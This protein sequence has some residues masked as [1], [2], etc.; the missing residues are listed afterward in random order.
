MATIMPAAVTRNVLTAAGP[1]AAPPPCA[2]NFDVPTTTSDRMTSI[3]L[4]GT[5]RAMCAWKRAV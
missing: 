1:A 2:A 4:R 3:R 5:L